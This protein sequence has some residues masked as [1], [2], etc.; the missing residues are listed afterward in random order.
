MHC[1]GAGDWLVPDLEVNA[2][3]AAKAGLMR[4]VQ[5]AVRMTGQRNTDIMTVDGE[6]LERAVAVK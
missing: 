6:L 1:G 2:R 3:F 4:M 5:K